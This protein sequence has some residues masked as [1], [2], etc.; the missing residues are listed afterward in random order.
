M[1]FLAGQWRSAAEFASSL[2]LLSE[3]TRREN[4]KKAHGKAQAYAAPQD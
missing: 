3:S 2:S 4:S 1:P